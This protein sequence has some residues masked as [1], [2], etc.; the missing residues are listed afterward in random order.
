M[1]IQG[2]NAPL[3]GKSSHHANRTRGSG[4]R[5]GVVDLAVVGEVADAVDGVFQEGRGGEDDQAGGFADIGED[6]EDFWTY[7]MLC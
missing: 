1:E 7:A 2:E 6:A 4:W 5:E 3:A